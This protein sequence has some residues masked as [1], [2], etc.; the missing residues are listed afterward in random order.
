MNKTRLTTVEEIVQQYFNQ[1]RNGT[2]SASRAKS[3]WKNMQPLLGKVKVSN[4]TGQHISKYT[5][6]R[7]S[8]AAPGTIN[9]ELG[10]LSAALRWANKQSYISQQIVIARLP[11]PEARQR[12]LTKDECK[13]LVQASKEYPHLYAFVG[14]ALLTG[15]RKEAILGLR[16]DQIFWDQGFVDFNDPSSPDH[17]RRKN[18][19]IVPLGV[20]LRQFLE[21][22]KSDCPYV[23]NKNGRRIRDLRKSW[24]KMVGEADLIGVTPHVLRHTVASHL[25][26]DGA[27]L[28]DVSRLLGHKDSRITEKV[29][30]KFSPDYLKTVSEKL[31]IA[32]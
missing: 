24:D 21:Q 26:M 31:S 18:R 10:V 30:A 32:A 11:T 16:Q 4:L 13:R 6:F 12:F 22:H 1:Y 23:V 29:Y 19:G 3:A 7:A 20:E 27:P 9:F 15:Q 2:I 5:K 8:Q 17:A 28:I 14:I 25:V